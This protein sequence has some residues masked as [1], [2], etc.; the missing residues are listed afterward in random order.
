MMFIPLL[1]RLLRVSICLWIF[2]FT[3]YQSFGFLAMMDISLP[4]L[5]TCL[6]IS[7]HTWGDVLKCSTLL[8]FS[9]PEPFI[10]HDVPS[11]LK[12]SFE[13]VNGPIDF[14]HYST[15]TIMPIQIKSKHSFPNINLL[16]RKKKIQDSLAQL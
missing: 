9:S 3:W 14:S 15:P 11:S 4:L 8:R 6:T 5:S 12:V 10:I 7:Y 13:S 16:R 1:R 2:L